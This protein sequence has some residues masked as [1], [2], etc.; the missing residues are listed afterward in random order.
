MM[1]DTFAFNTNNILHLLYQNKKK[2]Q[3]EIIKIQ[4]EKKKTFPFFFLLFDFFHQKWPPSSP[5]FFGEEA[6][7]PFPFFSRAFC[8]FVKMTNPLSLKPSALF[9]K[10]RW[11]VKA[12]SKFVAC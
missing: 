4:T 11:R 6:A 2:G 8:P 7:N 3:K 9:F 12:F 10:A 5:S 1:K